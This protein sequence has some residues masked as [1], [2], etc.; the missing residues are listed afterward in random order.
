MTAARASRSLKIGIVGAG[1][2]G[3]GIGKRLATANHD[4][5]VSFARSSEKLNAGAEAIGGGARAGS[6]EDAAGHGEVVIIATP[7]AVTLDIARQLADTLA[8]KILWD[9][10]N[11]ITPDMSGLELGTN[12]SAGDAIANVVP[13]ARV[14]KAIPPFA[15]VLHSPSGL[16]DGHKPAVFVCGD[17]SDAR[18][19]VLR[20]VADLDADAVDAGPLTMARYAEPLGML[21][22]QL[23]Y[24]QGMGA[25]IGS[26]LIRDDSP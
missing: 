23:A 20:L 5:V 15:E 16:I 2:A 1:N 6:P 4:I 10:T 21:L 12:T 24:V 7:W 8:G 25:R 9:T 17:D 11:P 14:V 3:V 19:L 22:V 18:N 26:V 13:A